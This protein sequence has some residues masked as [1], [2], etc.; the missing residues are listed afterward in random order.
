MIAPGDQWDD[1]R[2]GQHSAAGHFPAQPH[3][4]GELQHTGD[5]RPGAHHQDQHQAGDRRPRR[6]HDAAMTPR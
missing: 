3:R 4:G 1:S 2:N 6:G 5:H